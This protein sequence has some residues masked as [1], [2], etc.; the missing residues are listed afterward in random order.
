MSH[1]HH[2]HAFSFIKEILQVRPDIDLKLMKI[3]LWWNVVY[4]K[5][6]TLEYWLE[7]L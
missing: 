5:D 1:A 4:L 2:R 7:S 3:A 6:I